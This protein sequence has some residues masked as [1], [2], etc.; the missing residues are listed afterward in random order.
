MYSRA[1]KSR[2]KLGIVIKLQCSPHVTRQSLYRLRT[3][4]H[5]MTMINKTKFLKDA[6]FIIHM[7]YKYS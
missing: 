6:D 3:R 7:L 4:P 5:N 1:C 2:S